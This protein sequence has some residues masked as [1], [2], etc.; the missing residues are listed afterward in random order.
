MQQR[1]I[2]LP[3]IP[4]FKQFMAS[5]KSGRMPT[6]TH[7]PFAKG[8]IKQYQHVYQLLQAYEQ[9]YHLNLRLVLLKKQTLSLLKKEHKYWQHFFQHFSHYLYHEKGSYDAYSNAVFKI[10]RTFFNYLL[11]EKQLPVGLFHRQFKVP[12]HPLTPIVLQPE[13]LQFLINDK[14]FEQSL[15]RHLKRTKDIF[16][17]G[18]TV[19]L[20][21]G[22]L[23][24][25]K[26]ENIFPNGST[27]L[28][29]LYTQKTGTAVCIPLPSYLLSL[30][31]KYKGKTGRYLLPRLSGTNLNLQIKQLMEK[32]GWTQVL[33]KIRFLKGRPVEIKKEGRSLRFCDQI[34]AHSMRRTA[35]TTLLMLGVP[36]YMVRRVSGH[37]P[38]SQE[39]YRYVAVAQ[40][41][42]DR[43]LLDAYEKLVPQQD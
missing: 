16:V 39:F 34:S 42:M 36:E 37:A 11:H 13:Q 12:Q 31:R 33:P 24:K 9:K 26:K 43:T 4:L 21:Y 35:I 29:Q 20:R 28:L 10:I 18:C 7:K 30:L 38:H 32:A 23:M 22:D 40:T 2:Q 17:F 27:H 25:L 5:C 1:T 19:G 15:P 6:A 41:Y 14:A 8:T 3:L